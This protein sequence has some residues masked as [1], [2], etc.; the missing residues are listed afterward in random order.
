MHYRPHPTRHHRRVIVPS[1]VLQASPPHPPL[2][3]AHPVWRSRRVREEI[4]RILHAD[5]GPPL[6]PTT[7]LFVVPRLSPDTRPERRLSLLQRGGV[8]ALSQSRTPRTAVL[9]ARR[10]YGRCKRAHEGEQLAAV[11]RMSCGGRVNPRVQPHDVQV[12][13]PILLRVRDALE[14]VPMRTMGRRAPLC[15]S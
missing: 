15:R 13:N 8:H 9:R 1:T 3:R 2:Q 12:Q 6:L 5:E 14:N 4:C 7:D 11:P 10:R